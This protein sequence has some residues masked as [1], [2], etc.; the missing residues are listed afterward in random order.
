[1]KV[2]PS[3]A[4]WAPGRREASASSR[5]PGRRSARENIPGTS[6]QHAQRPPAPLL[7]SKEPRK[8]ARR[9]F[10][11]WK[12]VLAVQNTHRAV[13]LSQS[14]AA[15]CHPGLA[16][17]GRCKIKRSLQ[18]HPLLRGPPG[19]T[20]TICSRGFA[21]V[22]EASGMLLPFL[23][24]LL[25]SNYS[26]VITIS[27]RLHKESLYSASAPPPPAV[28]SEPRAKTNL[29]STKI[30]MTQGPGRR[31]RGEKDGE[32]LPQPTWPAV[33]PDGIR[34]ERCAVYTRRQG[35]RRCTLYL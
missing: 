3:S 35:E 6:H 29:G 21:E 13:S 10:A 27:A 31:K 1:M 12:G 2:W 30:N 14:L 17:A 25:S 18:V 5:S 9:T 7:G 34:W 32:G 11:L 28:L 33:P 16:G 8:G 20:H 22:A 4:G 19:A 23:V 26:R 24:Y 15:P